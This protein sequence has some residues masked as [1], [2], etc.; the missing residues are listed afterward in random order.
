MSRGDDR[1]RV[2]ERTDGGDQWTGSREGGSGGRQGGQRRGPHEG[3]SRG[4]QGGPSRGPQGGPSRGPRDRPPRGPRDEKDRARRGPIGWVFWFWDTDHAGVVFVREALSSVAIVLLIG[5]LLF[6]LSGVWPPMVAVESSSMY[7]NMRVGD[8]VFVMEPA[9]FP[10]GHAQ[11]ETGVVTY[12]VGQ[13]K[14]YTKFGRP[15]DVVVYQPNGRNHPTQIIH[16]AMFW[17][18]A[19]ENWYDEAD[20]SAIGGADSCREL[21]NCP[22]PHSG[23]IT[24]GDNNGEYDQVSPI[25]GDGTTCEPIKPSWIVGTAEF[26]IPKLGCIKLITTGQIGISCFF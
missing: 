16:R 22:A 2:A 10:P 7:P 19:G 23:F 11:E 3:T 8:L 14:G 9:R 5:F 21:P 4:P 13:E 17:V 12:Q 20:T 26:R 6:G 1:N 25:C 24:K 18:E 15:G